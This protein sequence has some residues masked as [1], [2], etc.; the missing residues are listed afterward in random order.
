MQKEIIIKNYR[1]RVIDAIKDITPLDR[2]LMHLNKGTSIYVANSLVKPEIF[3]Y[4]TQVSLT[5]GE[6]F[7]EMNSEKILE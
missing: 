3:R 7:K 4:S 6:V 2:K 1:L 5:M